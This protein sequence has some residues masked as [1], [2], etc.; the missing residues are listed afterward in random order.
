MAYTKEV[1]CPRCDGT[2]KLWDYTAQDLQIGTDEVPEHTVEVQCHV[3]LGQG[4]IR[5]DK[6]ATDDR[7]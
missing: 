3:C 1:P 7:A 4:H 6:E 2:G 5:V